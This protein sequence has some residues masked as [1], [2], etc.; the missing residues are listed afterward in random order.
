MAG[1]RDINHLAQ[2][3]FSSSNCA[4][5]RLGRLQSRFEPADFSFGE[6]DDDVVFGFEL[7]VDGRLRDP[8]RVGDHLQ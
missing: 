7:P 2:Q 5:F 4:P 6:R 1:D 8:D 3:D